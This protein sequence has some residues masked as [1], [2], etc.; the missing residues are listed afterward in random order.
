MKGRDELYK[1]QLDILESKAVYSTLKRE[2]NEE[3]VEAFKILALE[4]P[5]K[6]GAHPIYVSFLRK[7]VND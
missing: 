6:F 5:E 2:E 1:R 4:I 7:S 3:I